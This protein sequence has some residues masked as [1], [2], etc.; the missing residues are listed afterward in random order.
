LIR[1]ATL[2]ILFASAPAAASADW[3]IMPFLGTA[4]GGETTF[5]DLEQGA[6]QTKLTFGASVALLSDSFLG[7]EADFGHTPRFFRGDEVPLGPL[8]VSSRVTTFSGNVVVAAPLTLTRESL[9]PYLVGGLG[10]MQARAEDV[11]LILPV[12]Q[13]LL[14]LTV[15]GGAIGM[16]T[17]FTGVRFDVRHIK[18]ITGE[19]GQ[20]AREGT[21]RLSFWRASVALTLR[22]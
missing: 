17:P 16:V 14:G 20:F 22:Y 12:E 18:A 3:L 15:G 1:V 2:A 4:F 9:R 6:G 11:A 7:L 8:L 19:R 5:I 21:S 13:D 10:L